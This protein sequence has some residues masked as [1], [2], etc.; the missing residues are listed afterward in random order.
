VRSGYFGF[1]TL[2][3]AESRPVMAGRAR[4]CFETIKDFFTNK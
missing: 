1:F 2:P 3:L 4:V